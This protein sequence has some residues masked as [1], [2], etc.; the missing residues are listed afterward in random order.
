[1][2]PAHLRS[3]ANPQRP[4]LRQAESPGVK[5]QAGIPMRCW[6]SAEARARGRGRISATPQRSGHEADLLKRRNFLSA[7]HAATW[8]RCNAGWTNPESIAAMH[9]ALARVLLALPYKT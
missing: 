8:R 2:E 1:M 7:R 6:L 5:H 3:E 9:P 4:P